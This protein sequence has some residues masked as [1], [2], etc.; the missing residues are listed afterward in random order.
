MS[1]TFTI[2]GRTLSE[3]AAGVEDYSFLLAVPGRRGENVKVPGRHGEI[4]T[5]RK[6]WEALE[7]PIPLWV[8]GIDPDT[9]LVP[10]DPISQLHANVKA[11]LLEVSGETFTLGHTLDDGTSVRAVAELT[12]DPT[13]FARARSVPPLARVSL[14]TTVP[15]GFWFDTDTVSHTIT[16]ATGTTSALTEFVGASAPMAD[17]TITWGPCNNPQ[18]TVGDRY[19]KYSGVV[20]SGRQLVI[21]T[22]SWSVSTG[23]GTAW[24]PD[25]RL[26][27]FG[28]SAGRWFELDPTVSPFEAAITHT[29]GGSATCTVSGR[30][31]YL[32]AA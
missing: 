8:K 6:R 4:R 5:P 1:E 31:A 32:F 22:G 14:E 10:A 2:N 20:A 28:P 23:T 16:G 25:M 24:T 27:E 13:V 19:V 7:L 3:F 15:E 9:G 30:R 29:G 26:I 11:L 12:L 18:L 21:D 17:L